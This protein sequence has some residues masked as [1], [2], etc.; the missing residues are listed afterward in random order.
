[1]I[2]DAE[3]GYDAT[4]TDEQAS[5][6]PPPLPVYDQPE[7]PDPDL[8]WTPGYWAYAPYGYYW[9][10]GAWCAPPYIGALWTPGYWGFYGGR[11]RFHHGFWGPYIGYYGGV[12]YGF[13]YVGVGYLGGYW[14]GPHFYYNRNFNR[15]GPG[16]RNVYVRD[17]TFNNVHYNNYAVNTRLGPRVSYNG[18]NGG[19]RATP[20]PAELAALR[21]PRVAPMSSQV[22]AQR[23]A[24]Q[25]R[26]QFYG[27][28]QGRPA[29]AATPRPFPAERGVA[30]PARTTADLERPGTQAQP[31]QMG[32]RQAIIES[33][34]GQTASQLQPG[35]TA[36]PMDNR[37]GT[38]GIGSPQQPPPP[39]SE[40]RRVPPRQPNPGWQQAPQPQPS[41]RPQEPVQPQQAQPRPEPQTYPQPTPRPQM[42]PQPEVRPQQ[43]LQPPR[44]Q[45][46]PQPQRPQPQPQNSH[47]HSHRCSPTHKHRR[48][49]TPHPT[50]SGSARCGFAL[51]RP[52]L[53]GSR[54]GVRMRT[55]GRFRASKRR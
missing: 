9:V 52:A 43:Q 20:R 31:G 34:P 2:Q 15:V 39:Q 55:D 24:A 5:A 22:Q 6:P 25:N 51:P 29:I 40:V 30:A 37:T 18:G 44:P 19:V 35:Q 13:G 36:R 45:P 21:Q 16:V 53:C 12:N 10:P 28:N 47:G 49:R 26:Q 54:G 14:N 46:Q 23:E 50:P 42:P 17:V 11:Y 3:A 4:L 38:P 33:H 32:P 27:A 41:A 8:I 1:M 48:N 7:A